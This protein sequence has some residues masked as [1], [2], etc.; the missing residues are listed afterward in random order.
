MITKVGIVYSI[1]QNVR[2][3]LIKYTWD[4]SEADVHKKCLADGEGWLDIDIDLYNKFSI[5]YSQ[6]SDLDIHIASIIGQPKDD[7][8]TIVADTGE[9][10]GSICADP[11]IDSKEEGFLI[12]D[13][14]AIGAIH[15]DFK[16]QTAIKLE[17][18]ADTAITDEVLP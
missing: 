18:V 11:I 12:V 6:L 15:Y 14:K 16:T 8:C 9:V 7:R 10:F 1:D 3:R 2:R 13:P 5:N 17:D 4:D